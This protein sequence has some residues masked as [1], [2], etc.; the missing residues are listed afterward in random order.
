MT[1]HIVVISDGDPTAPTPAV[2]NQL[3]ATRSP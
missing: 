1:K 3:V 2:I